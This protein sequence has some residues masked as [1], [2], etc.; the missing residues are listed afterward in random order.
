MKSGNSSTREGS[1]SQHS[2]GKGGVKK[3]CYLNFDNA[4]NGIP[5]PSSN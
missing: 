3:S 2:V 5:P 1:I 4:Y